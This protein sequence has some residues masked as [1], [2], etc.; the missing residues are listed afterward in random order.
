MNSSFLV[1][2]AAGISLIAGLMAL[3][4]SRYLV[5]FFYLCYTLPFLPLISAVFEED[6]EFWIG[7]AF[8]YGHE[9][10]HVYGLALIWLF[11]TLGILSALLLVG[12]RERFR[13]ANREP[14][15]PPRFFDVSVPTRSAVG[16]FSLGAC[17][18]LIIGRFFAGGAIEAVFPGMDPL[19]CVLI[20]F[21]G[22]L[23]LLDR[24]NTGYI[25]LTSLVLVY[26]FSQLS[27][28]DRDFFTFIIAFVLLWMVRNKV[29]LL[30]F[31]KISVGGFVLVALGAAVSMLRMDVQL[32]FDDL[33]IFLRF[34]SWNAIILPVLSMIEAEWEAG[35]LLLG[36]TYLDLFLSLAP[37]PFFG[38]FGVE[39]P[40]TSDNPANWFYIEGLGGMHASGVALRNFGLVGVFFQAFVFTASLAVVENMVLRRESVLRLFLFLSIAASVM[41]GIWYGLIYIANAVLFFSVVSFFVLFLSLSDVKGSRKSI[42]QP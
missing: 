38:L 21:C 12:G 30:L 22:S 20:V 25:F 16:I 17:A 4:S 8:S 28:G 32:S 36:K 35:P 5:G 34:N 42:V 37:S 24:N 19:I 6:A 27:T 29:S 33:S 7:S 13:R 11:S 31:I 1:P 2:I 9:S 23:V 15:Y 39:K 10:L 40:I 18:S 14:I 26:V 41:H 3:A